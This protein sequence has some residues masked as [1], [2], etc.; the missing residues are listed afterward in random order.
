M[1]NI[2]KNIGRAFC[3]V[4]Y[5]PDKLLNHQR[6]EPKKPEPKMPDWYRPGEEMESTFEHFRDW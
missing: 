3:Y 6:Q 4:F 1:S 5:L 2:L